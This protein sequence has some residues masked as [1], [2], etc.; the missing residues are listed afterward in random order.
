MEDTHNYASLT[1]A[2]SRV[3]IAKKYSMSKQTNNMCIGFAF[4]F[5]SPGIFFKTRSVHMDAKAIGFI[6]DIYRRNLRLIFFKSALL[7]EKCRFESQSEA[8]SSCI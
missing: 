2:A 6:N 1:C 4:R 3:V 8:F 7:G 5:F